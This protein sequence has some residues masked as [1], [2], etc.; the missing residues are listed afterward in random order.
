VSTW[1]SFNPSLI[2][3]AGLLDCEQAPSGATYRGAEYMD[4]IKSINWENVLYAVFTLLAASGVTFTWL[5][6]MCQTIQST[7]LRVE[8]H[9]DEIREIV[10]E[11]RKLIEENK[12][13][14]Q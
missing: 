13:A 2:S 4:F 8:E 6:K 3:S 5:K 14:K 1:I 7:N 12:E 11:M 10:A 9:R